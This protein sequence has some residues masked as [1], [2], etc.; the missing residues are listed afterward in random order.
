MNV[1]ED[2]Q[3]K[4]IKCQ[5]YYNIRKNIMNKNEVFIIFI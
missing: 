1:E 2:K 3:L 5:L 4:E